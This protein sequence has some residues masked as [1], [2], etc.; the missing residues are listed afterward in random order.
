MVHALAETR[1]RTV[2]HKKYVKTEVYHNGVEVSHKWVEKT[3]KE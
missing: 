2:L 1:Q 3:C